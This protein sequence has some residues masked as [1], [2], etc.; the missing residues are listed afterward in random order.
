MN[1]PHYKR[2]TIRKDGT[3]KRVGDDAVVSDAPASP[4]ESGSTSGGEQKHPTETEG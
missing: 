4:D 3:F 2:G 1:N